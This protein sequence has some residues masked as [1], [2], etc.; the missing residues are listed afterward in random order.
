MF[1]EI[2]AGTSDAPTPAAT[3]AKVVSMRGDS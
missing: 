1:R 3:N 2:A